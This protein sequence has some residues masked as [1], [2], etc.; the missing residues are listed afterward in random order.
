MNK[1]LESFPRDNFNLLRIDPIPVV[2]HVSQLVGTAFLTV[3]LLGLVAEPGQTQVEPTLKVGVV[4][5]F[6]SKP[7]DTMTL[8]PLQGDRLD[9][10]FETGGQTQTVTT[11][12]SVELDIT[13]QPLSQPQLAEKVVLSIHR[14]FESAEDNANQW[15]ARGIQVEIAQP[16]QWQVWAKRGTYN[17]P[18]LR[19]LLMQNLQSH[20]SETAFIDSQVQKE[21]PKAAFTVNGFRFQRDQVE[22]ASGT[23]RVAVTL[24]LDPST[25]KVYGGSLQLRPNAY[26][27]YT[28]VNDVSLETYLRG[29][30]PHEI[31]AGAPQTAME[32]QAILARTYALRNLRRFAIDNYQL[33]ADTQ[34]QVYNGLTGAIPPTDQAIASTQG[35]VLTYQNELVDALYSSTTGGITAPF[36]DVWNGPDRPYLR[37][38]VDSIYGIWDLSR[39]SLADER[40]FQTFIS[41]S[42]G[43]NEEGWDV[44]RWR[45]ESTLPQIAAGLREYLKNKQHPL[46]NLSQVSRV[47]ITERSPAGRVQRMAIHTDLGVLELEKDE[48]LR[49]LY[50]PIS[51][52]FYIEPIYEEVVPPSP[53]SQTTTSP[54]STPD[55]VVVASAPT[56]SSIPT[57]TTSGASPTPTAP[58]ATPSSPLPT[59]IRVLKGYTFIGGGFGHGVGMSQTGS[60]RLGE[61]G[62]PSDRI[63]SFYFPG[64][65]VRSLSQQ[66]IFWR[67]PVQPAST[68][69]DR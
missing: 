20:G 65:Q 48:I 39:Y 12:G 21:I 26:G 68:S 59:P 58:A 6:G 15:Q 22:I 40:N 29:V 8:Q 37:P 62:W 55:S 61:L 7:T 18:L 27:T 28:L 36:S 38:V 30:V 3:C 42:Q 60:Y 1:Q 44:F 47:E 24:D 10:K 49:A 54:Q 11:T 9:L 14:S 2:E 46:A 69:N 45:E 34:C 43:F 41:R 64:T 16:R 19:R 67:N 57:P 23:K 53:V 33:C 51:T 66:I 4:Q 50:A 52:L 63:L 25:Q 31:G 35:L 32:A 13:P 17:T 5:R 56:L